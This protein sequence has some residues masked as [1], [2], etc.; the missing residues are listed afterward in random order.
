MKE[1]GVLALKALFSSEKKNLS[2]TQTEKL[3]QYGPES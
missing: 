1:K 2:Q 3:K